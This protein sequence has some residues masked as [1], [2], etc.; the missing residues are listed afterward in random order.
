MEL[1]VVIFKINDYQ[2]AV[3]NNEIISVITLNDRSSFHNNCITYK[4]RIIPVINMKDHQEEKKSQNFFLIVNIAQNQVSILADDVFGIK[5]L[6][7][8]N[9]YPLP[10]AIDNVIKLD[11]IW[12]IGIIE[13]QLYFLI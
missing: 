13:E 3:D 7:K 9:I 6:K 11:F 5:T 1:K 4:G 10:Q 2:F 8:E 12:G